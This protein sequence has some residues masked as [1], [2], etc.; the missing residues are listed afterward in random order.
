MKTTWI[1]STVMTAAIA[2]A[3]VGYFAK[4]RLVRRGAP[5]GQDVNG[6]LNASPQD[7]QL[8]S[9]SEACFGSVT[10][11]VSKAALNERYRWAHNL[12][13]QKLFEAALPDLRDIAVLDPGFPG[14]NLDISAS[15]LQLKRTGEAKSAID[16]QIA[17]SDCVSRLPPEELL[18]YCKSEL[19]AMTLGN[20]QDEL[21]RI[22]QA[23]QL[24]ASL[25]QMELGN[26][27][28]VINTARVISP[29]R[30][31]PA[32]VRSSPPQRRVTTARRASAKNSPDQS[33]VD[34]DGT[35]SS[36]GYARPQ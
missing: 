5:G 33:L 30:V 32:I 26:K 25:V 28:P 20:C 7:A 10:S 29:A 21:G 11:G 36:L 17:I 15:L 9:A 16:S 6:P 8:A 18:A 1:A 2:V 23:A 13:D 31:T 22:Q 19:S 3:A 14:V 4:P 34:G 12:I 35:D 27:S 24:Q